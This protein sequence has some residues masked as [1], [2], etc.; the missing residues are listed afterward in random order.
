LENKEEEEEEFFD[1]VSLCGPSW[2]PV[3]YVGQSSLCLLRTGMKNIHIPPHLTIFKNNITNIP[4]FIL[5]L[6]VC[7]SLLRIKTRTYL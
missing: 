3:L 1:R 4:G 5:C 6:S 2:P 7:L